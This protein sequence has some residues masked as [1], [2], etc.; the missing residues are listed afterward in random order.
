MRMLKGG[1]METREMICIGCPLG[2]NLT[3]KIDGENIEVSGNTCKNGERY[4][5][6]EVTNPTRVVT[7]TI[8]VLDGGEVRVSCKTERPIPKN[9]IFACMEEIKKATVKA[10]VK[11]GDVLIKD[12]AG[13]D[14]NVIATKN[15]K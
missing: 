8:K 3:V 12:V 9:K 6:D 11:I 2:C 1:I 10:P 13:T 4:A 7:S 15:V 5:R 14:I